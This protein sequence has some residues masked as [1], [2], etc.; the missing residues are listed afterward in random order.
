M[1]PRIDRATIASNRVSNRCVFFS[2]L[3]VPSL[4]LDP[5]AASFLAAPEQRPS[6]DQ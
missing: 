2:R 1:D 3:L 5:P 4:L 6:F